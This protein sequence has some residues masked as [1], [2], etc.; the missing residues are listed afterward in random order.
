MIE[1]K[2]NKVSKKDGKERRRKPQRVRGEEYHEKEEDGR[3]RRRKEFERFERRMKEAVTFS[4]I[5]TKEHLSEQLIFDGL[6][7]PFIFG[8]GWG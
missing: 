3:N 4:S 2:D 7:I 6:F 1:S 5:Q 8:M